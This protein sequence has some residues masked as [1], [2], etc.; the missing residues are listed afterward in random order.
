MALLTCSCKQVDSTRVH[1]KSES[2]LGGHFRHRP[3]S[4]NCGIAD[5]CPSAHLEKSPEEISI[6][7][8]EPAGA[9]EMENRPHTIRGQACSEERSSSHRLL[10]P[11]AVVHVSAFS[12]ALLTLANPPVP[13]VIKEQYSQ[14][15]LSFHRRA[16]RAR[17]LNIRSSHLHLHPMV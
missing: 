8:L 11:D 6:C 13:A 14:R 17:K 12:P 3:S 5:I 2:R 7:P 15:P 1:G 16:F 9:A 4:T 10:H